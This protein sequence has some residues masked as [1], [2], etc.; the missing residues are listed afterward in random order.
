MGLTPE[1][2]AAVDPAVRTVRS[3]VARWLP[4]GAEVV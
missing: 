4:A 3:L 1:V 2:E